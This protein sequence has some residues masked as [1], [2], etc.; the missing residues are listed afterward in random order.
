MILLKFDEI[1][2]RTDV[3]CHLRNLNT[4][5]MEK[6]IFDTNAYR[7]LVS[8]KEYDEIDKIIEKIKKKEKAR[9]IESLISPI[10]AKELL[11]HVASK[12][13]PHFDKCLKAIKALYLHSGD[14]NSYNQ[15]AS[16]ELLIAKSFFN[17]TLPSKEETNKAL[18][19]I[20]FNLAKRPSDYVFKRFQRNLN[21]NRE[22]VLDNENNFANTLLKFVKGL[23]PTAKGWRVFPDD[24]IKRKKALEY[25]R[26][27]EVSL[28]IAAG[29]I[30]TV[31]S[32]LKSDGKNIKI[33][34]GIL[35]DM[36]V[37]FIKTFPEVIALY[38]VVFENLVN[39]EFNLMEN[40]R[41]NFV[42]DIHL[43][44]NVGDHS[45]SGETLYFVTDDK[46]VIRTAIAE[47]SKLRILTFDEYL[48]Y[49][50]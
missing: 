27:S 29:Y 9:N 16:P 28:D 4:T 50:N 46:A 40:S 22:H 8:N 36:S 25:I 38:K 18:I 31:Y 2:K 10:V 14:D 26:S 30:V 1:F 45:I 43:M 33:D 32:L 20:A 5:N 49:I 12:K 44:F 21:L 15:I 3:C 13:D 39:S 17:H 7:Y 34:Y 19:Q 41:S 48:E 37:K 24:P 23:D 6:V 42:W 47:N 35:F 11:A